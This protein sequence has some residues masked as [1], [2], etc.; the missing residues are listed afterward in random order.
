M[1]VRIVQEIIG[2]VAKESSNEPALPYF[3][4]ALASALKSRHSN[5]AIIY[6]H[7]S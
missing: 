3:K 6:T 5:R 2:V 4:M 1:A 7:N